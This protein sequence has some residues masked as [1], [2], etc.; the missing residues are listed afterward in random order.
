MNQRRSSAFVNTAFCKTLRNIA[1]Y[2]LIS[3]STVLVLAFIKKLYCR[4]CLEAVGSLRWQR[5]LDRTATSRK[6]RERAFEIC[7]WINANLK[8]Y[9][10][11]VY[12]KLFAMALMACGSIFH[13]ACSMTRFCNV[14]GVSSGKTSTAFW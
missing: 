10:I 1:K 6:Q 9:Y 7:F 11:C 14:S 12:N 5:Q 8:L 13:S 3:F 2:Y 4:K